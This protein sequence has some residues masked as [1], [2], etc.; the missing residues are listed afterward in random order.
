MV[1]ILKDTVISRTG[2]PEKQA[3][4]GSDSN[5]YHLVPE[6]SIEENLLMNIWEIF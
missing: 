3:N 1:V 4:P 5:L 2:L 6:D